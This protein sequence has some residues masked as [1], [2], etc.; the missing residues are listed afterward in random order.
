M[1]QGFIFQVLVLKFGVRD[2]VYKPLIPQRET[3]V[4]LVSSKLWIMMCAGW[5]KVSKI[6][7]QPFLPTSGWFPPDV[8]RLFFQFLLVFCFALFPLEELVLY[9]AV[10]L[11]CSWEEINSGSSYLTILNQNLAWYSNLF[12]RVLT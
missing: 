2:V 8:K 4:L 7:S 9:I 5:G 10:D 3:L 12:N 1:F 11:V 6:V